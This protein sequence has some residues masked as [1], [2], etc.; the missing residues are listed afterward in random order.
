MECKTSLPPIVNQRGKEFVLPIIKEIRLL[1]LV[2]PEFEIKQWDLCG[3][4]DEEV[5]LW[6]T[7]KISLKKKDFYEFVKIVSA[8]H[9]LWRED[10]LE[11]EFIIRLLKR[12]SSE[13]IRKINPR[14]A[15]KFGE[16]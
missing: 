9:D 4:M 11:T 5:D 14:C 1:P 3:D 12:E 2:Y 13:K 15:T 8:S 7:M 16:T 6:V 10:R